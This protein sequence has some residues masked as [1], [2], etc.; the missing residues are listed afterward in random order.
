V[1]VNRLGAELIS[2]PA[3]LRAVEKQT[4]GEVDSYDRILGGAMHRD[5]MLFVREYAVEAA[6]A[7]VEP[8][9]G[10]ASALHS[11]EPGS[12]GPHGADRLTTDVDGWHSPE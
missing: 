3:N 10:N 2:M 5:G 9:L 11:Y 4:A 1:Q 7:V 6:W 12:W 8:I